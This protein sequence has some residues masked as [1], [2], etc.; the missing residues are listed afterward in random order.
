MGRD[1]KKKINKG[2]EK[3]NLK[4][5][6]LNWT[7]EEIINAYKNNS[8]SLEIKNANVEYKELYGS[9]TYMMKKNFSM[10]SEMLGIGT[11][12]GYYFVSKVRLQKYL[13]TIRE[14]FATTKRR[15]S[16]EVQFVICFI[17]AKATKKN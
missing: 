6:P 13:T 5:I 2:Q 1:N 12:Y 11:G 4:D 15:M 7:E 8:S 16:D 10:T 9:F 3:V 17:G 14:I